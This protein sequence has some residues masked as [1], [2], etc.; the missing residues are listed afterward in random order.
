MAANRALRVVVV[1]DDRDTIETL[2]WLL[3]MEG[4]EVVGCHAGQ[5]A[6][7]KACAHQADVVIIDLA[8]PEVDG[9]EVARQ[10]RQRDACKDA[11]LIAVT[12]YANEEHRQRAMQ[13]GFDDY[14]VKPVDL[15]VVH[16][17]LQARKSRHAGPA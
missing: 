11:L 6:I 2:V 7:E 9:Y 16:K 15:A 8:M 4:H 17:A 1:D 14:L 13:V 3:Q 12:G 10:L 5:D